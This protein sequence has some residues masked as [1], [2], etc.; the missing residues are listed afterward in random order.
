MSE[1]KTQI[2][3]LFSGG[4]DS[5][6]AAALACEQFDTTHLL[7]YFHSGI[8]LTEKAKI[9]ARKLSDYFG[10]DKIVHRFI[11]FEETFK[12]IYYTNY[13][14]DLLKYKGYMN[15]CFCN[16]CQLAMHTSTILYNLNNDIYYTCDGYKREKGHLYVFMSKEGIEKLKSL[17]NCFSIEYKNPVYDI[18]RTDWKL[19]EM[20]ITTKKNVKFPHER[21]DFSTQHHCPVGIIVNAYLMG[22]F[23]PLYGQKANLNISAKYMSEKIASSKKYIDTVYQKL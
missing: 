13:I 15:P 3:V 11:N 8:P 9:N 23:F 10:K 2:S 16:A 17:Y 6:L 22:Y 4:S 18:P 14:N 20:G 12:Q 21:L 1:N 5:T 7:T 19:F